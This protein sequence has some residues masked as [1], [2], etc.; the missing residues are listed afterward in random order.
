MMG[1]GAAPLLHQAKTT[2]EGGEE[3]DTSYEP[4]SCL[5]QGQDQGLT[6]FPPLS[7]DAAAIELIRQRGALDDKCK[8]ES[9]SGRRYSGR[10]AQ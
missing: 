1:G 9:Q 7:Q 4:P 6:D 3:G 2:G 10:T 8:K 5:D